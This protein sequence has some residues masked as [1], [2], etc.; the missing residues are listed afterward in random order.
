MYGNN[1]VAKVAY[2]Q[3][4]LFIGKSNEIETTLKE[5]LRK[6]LQVNYYHSL[7]VRIHQ[8]SYDSNTD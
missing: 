6:K 3:A 8:N 2:I 4:K 1:T 7:S 5:I